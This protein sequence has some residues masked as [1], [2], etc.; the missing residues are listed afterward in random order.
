MDHSGRT[1]EEYERDCEDMF[2]AEHPRC[3][4]CGEAG[5]KDVVAC[6]WEHG[7]GRDGRPLTPIAMS[8]GDTVLVHSGACYRLAKDSDIEVE[9]AATVCK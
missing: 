1:E 4:V 2:I 5:C 9:Q 3:E 7:S 6:S 8:N